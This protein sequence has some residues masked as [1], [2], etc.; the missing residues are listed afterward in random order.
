MVTYRL[1]VLE[2]NGGVNTAIDDGLGGVHADTDRGVVLWLHAKVARES[3][4]KTKK[5]NAQFIAG[6]PRS[7]HATHSSIWILP[8]S[9]T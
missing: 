1:D 7:N 8:N 4:S 9:P 6:F 2:P 3:I 5:V